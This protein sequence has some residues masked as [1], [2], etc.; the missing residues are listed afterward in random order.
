MIRKRFVVLFSLL[1]SIVL[2]ISACSGSNQ[3]AT[4]SKEDGKENTEEVV[5]FKFVSSK[6]DAALTEVLKEMAKSMEEKS[7]GTLKPELYI[8]GQL[9][10]N[11]EDTATGLIEKQYELLING[12]WF[13]A[14]HSPEWVNLLN[15]PFVLRD[16]EH[17]QNFW[18]SEIGDMLNKKT[19][20]EY[21]VKSYTETIGLRGARYLTANKPIKN[22]DDLKGI[23]MRTPSNAG[24]VASWEAAGANVTPIPWGELYGALQSGVV[25]AQENPAANIDSIA[26]Y[27]VQ[28]Y[29]MQTAHQYIAFI[30]HMDNT[31]FNSLSEKQQK[32]ITDS[33]DEGFTTYN[34]RII[35]EEGTLFEK[36]KQ[37]GMTIIPPEEIDIESMK[38]RITP[39]VL[40]E[41]NEKLPEGGY[42]KIQ[43]IK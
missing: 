26:M 25:D 36:F 14:F 40:E 9:G 38:Q 28:D 19:L 3:T 17:L 12:D 4:S 33:I 32:A 13:A 18:T 24:V 37:N 21:D 6:Q 20:E 10:N 2:V 7:G 15:V 11:D 30:A 22:V 1:L 41:L 5:K 31:W 42:E 8:E 34:Q 23:K 27:Q 35:D 29:L 43:D 39:T 16:G